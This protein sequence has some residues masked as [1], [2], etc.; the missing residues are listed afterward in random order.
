M[1]MMVAVAFPV[2]A[3]GGSESAGASGTGTLTT[4]SGVLLSSPTASP[5][6]SAG[7]TPIS[8]LPAPVANELNSIFKPVNSA[9]DAWAYLLAVMFAFLFSGAVREW[10]NP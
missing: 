4:V 2:L 8:A 7:G 1:V 6:A 10:V 9:D 5:A 3:S